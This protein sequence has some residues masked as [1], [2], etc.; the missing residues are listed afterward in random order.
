MKLGWGWVQRRF[1][2]FR[3]GHRTY[4]A[5]ILS[6]WNFIII[7]YKLFISGVPFLATIELWMFILSFI[8]IYPLLAI[9][10]GYFLYRKR[11]YH[12]DLTISTIEHP[13]LYKLRPGRE[14]DITFPLQRLSLELN[15]RL[16]EKFDLMTG[17]EKYK[18]QQIMEKLNKLLEGES[19]Q[20]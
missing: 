5:F 1:W 3:Y 9:G 7:T 2:D 8:I 17:E 19:I 20:K 4:L 13:Y 14:T 11:Q 12:T 6:L 18:L 10:I 15:M 16:W